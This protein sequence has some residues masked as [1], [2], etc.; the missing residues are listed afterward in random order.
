MNA[1]VPTFAQLRAFAAV[2]EFLHFGSAAAELGVTQPA[3]SAALTGCEEALGVRLVE[4]TTRMVRLTEAGHHL[5]PQ[6]REALNAVD[7][8]MTRADDAG[9]A[10][11][12]MRRIGIIPTVAPYVLPAV[13]R[14]LRNHHPGIEPRVHEMQTTEIMRGL[15]S[16]MLDFGICA[17]PTPSDSVE[18]PLYVERLLAAIPKE[19]DPVAPPQFSLEDLADENVLMLEDGH[20]LRD[21]TLQLCQ[22]SG[23]VPGM[24]S[25]A[26]GI[27]TLLRLVEAD[28]GV[29]VVPETAAKGERA[30]LGVAFRQLED[31]EA[32]RTVGL[33]HRPGDD[34]ADQ[35][36]ELVEVIKKAVRQRRLP[37]QIHQP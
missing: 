23:F 1:R 31:H 30:A 10:H 17:L 29:A 14:A 34:R 37:V 21:Q 4:R 24:R 5:L 15:E 7:A 12:G 6:A 20:C 8:F 3:L 26:T 32:R 33:V 9:K 27:P 16:G 25:S 35:H 2:A 13:L 28:L 22:R 18:C 11:S 36:V 19:R